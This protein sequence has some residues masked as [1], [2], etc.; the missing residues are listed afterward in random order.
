MQSIIRTD[1]RSMKDDI[2][3]FFDQEM[4]LYELVG[5]I[6][7]TASVIDYDPKKISFQIYGNKQDIRRLT[8]V[9]SS[10]NRVMEYDKPLGVDYSITSDKSINIYIKSI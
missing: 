3:D 5:S 10:I 7:H 9:L 2:I 4:L 1:D 6:N 8:S